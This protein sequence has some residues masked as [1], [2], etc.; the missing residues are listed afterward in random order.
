MDSRILE[1]HAQDCRLDHETRFSWSRARVIP[2]ERMSP[3]CFHR[4]SVP[5]LVYLLWISGCTTVQSQPSPLVTAAGT[6]AERRSIVPPSPVDS[7]SAAKVANEACPADLSKPASLGDAQIEQPSDEQPRSKSL[8]GSE[9]LNPFPRPAEQGCLVPKPVDL[10]I[11]R[12]IHRMAEI[13]P[14]QFDGNMSS[15]FAQRRPDGL[16]TSEDPAPTSDANPAEETTTSRSPNPGSFVEDQVQEA[17]LRFAQT[18]MNQGLPPP[19]TNPGGT[20]ERQFPGTNTMRSIV[21]RPTPSGVTVEVPAGTRGGLIEPPMKTKDVTRADLP[22]WLSAHAQ[23]TVIVQV[24][25]PFSSPYSGTNSF[26]PVN[27]PATSETSTIF[28][29][30][31]LWKG[32]ELIVNPEI[33]GGTGLSGVTG[34]AGFPNGEITRVGVPSPSLY[35]ARLL[36]RQ[37]WG[38]GGEQET[39]EEGANQ[40]AGT[41]D[42]HRLT[43]FVG[44]MAFTDIIDNNRHSHDPRTQLMNWSMMYNGAWDFPADVRGYD[45]G[46]AVDYN[47]TN[48]ALRYGIMGEPEIANGPNIDPHVLKAYGQALEFQRRLVLNNRPGALRLMAYLNKADMGSYREALAQ[49]P[50]DPNIIS[51]RS[52]R[53]KYGFGANYEQDI[54]ED[55]GVWARAGWNDGQ[56]ES[57][58]FTEI[59]QTV[60]LGLLLT[61][62]HWNRPQDEVGVGAVINGLSAAHREYLAA[63]GL[64]FILGDGKL[65][66]ANEEIIET[67][68]NFKITNGITVSGDLQGVR[69][70]GYNADRGPVVVAAMRLHFEY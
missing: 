43:V 22:P 9:H 36:L 61:G 24:N 69:N 5:G 59:D 35:F 53:D 64:G 20:T 54:T 34:I 30:A 14:A 10:P 63:G 48:W 11:N 41:R 39:L 51:T 42:V 25:A 18:D 58:A 28:L 46:M 45:Y 31:A 17:G 68:Y 13:D 57:W 12:T 26:K 1:P 44:R 52:Y 38:F 49:L 60:A 3:I 37:T 2:Y 40:V 32:A 70:P 15:T 4:Y 56:T 23:T 67:Y 55:L 66:Y 33:A 27:G 65:N 21:E 50:V 47:R 19:I 16:S 62:D 7:D 8:A 29:D 6:N